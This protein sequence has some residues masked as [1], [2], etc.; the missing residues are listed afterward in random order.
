MSE[1]QTL[2]LERRGPVAIVTMQRAA[3]FNAMSRG[4]AE[5]YL[6]VLSEI[7]RD[8]SLRVVILTGEGKAFCSG[9]DLKEGFPPDIEAVIL[10]LYGPVMQAVRRLDKVVIAAVNG[11]V[12]GIG[13][14]LV[15]S[16]D[17]AVMAEEGYIQLA[18]SKI[19][20]VPDGGLTWDFVRAVGHKRAYR[21]M[22][23]ATKLPASEC[24]EYG[25]VNEVVP[26]EQVMPFALQWAEQI[27]Q[28][29]P[30]ACQVTKR[31]L[32]NSVDA[33][34]GQAIAYEATLQQRAGASGDCKE[35][36]TAF[37]EKRAPVYPG[38]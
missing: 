18:F 32:H 24:R 5:E 14:A 23:E 7:E 17:L 4:M 31:A 35:G 21:M 36:V 28:L 13:A 29:S 3:A 12:A 20:L 11:I 30:V 26:G 33:A 1:L 8:E 34:F 2:K 10:K 19:G 16:A 9:A 37:L 38:R 6:R 25:L 27:A 22:I 15:T